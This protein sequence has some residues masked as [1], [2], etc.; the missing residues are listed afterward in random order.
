ME[1]NLKIHHIIDD[2]LADSY[3]PLSLLGNENLTVK[4]VGSAV[5]QLRVHPTIGLNRLARSV[6]NWF[7]ASIA[8]WLLGF[9]F[10]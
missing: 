6:A 2:N 8:V 7:T 9:L 1:Q 3:A 10:S 5:S 4:S